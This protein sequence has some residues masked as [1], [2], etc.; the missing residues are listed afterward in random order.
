MFKLDNTK[1][2][3]V[4]LGYV[5]LPLAIEFSKKYSVKGFDVDSIRVSELNSGFDST[6]ELNED[7]LKNAQNITYSDRLDDIVDCNLYVLTVPTP[8]DSDKNPDVSLLLR[9]SEMIGSIIGKNDI[10]IYESTVYPGATEELCV[11][12]LEKTSGL[13]YNKDFFV[14]Y[15]PE[16]INPGDKEHRAN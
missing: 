9:A 5:G 6:L 12:V 3:V 1:I 16:R 14:G 2:G 13:T 7:E 8:I 11:P 4:G 15:S 10:L